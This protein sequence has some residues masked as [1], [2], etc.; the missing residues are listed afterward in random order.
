MQKLGVAKGKKFSSLSFRLEW[1][2]LYSFML[3]FIGYRVL[4][5]MYLNDYYA[6][7]PLNVQNFYVNSI[8]L[9]YLNLLYP[10]ITIC[11]FIVC[12]KTSFYDKRN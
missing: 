9:A 5:F 12:K 1:R 7:V 10:E 2:V 8:A 6:H 11:L 4:P 3:I